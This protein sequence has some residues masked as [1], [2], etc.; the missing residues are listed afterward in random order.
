MQPFLTHHEDTDSSSTLELQSHDLVNQMF[1]VFSV[2]ERV[3]SSALQG[4]LESASSFYI[5]W[6]SKMKDGSSPNAMCVK[7]DGTCS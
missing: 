3:A 4:T 2:L 1:A 5:L 7:V 6:L